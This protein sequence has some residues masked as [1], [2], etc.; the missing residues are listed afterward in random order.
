MS[1][2]HQPLLPGEPIPAGLSQALRDL[3]NIHAAYQ[4]ER[5]SQV[6]DVAW[7]DLD[8]DTHELAAD[9]GIEKPESH[10]ERLAIH[11]A[12]EDW[13]RSY[14]AGVDYAARW[15]QGCQTPTEPDTYDITLSGGGPGSCLVG[16]F[17]LG[18]AIDPGTAHYIG[19]DTQGTYQLKPWDEHQESTAWFAQLVAA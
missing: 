13:A 4:L 11:D 1:Y 10:L 16:D 2:S 5:Y 14:H 6:S 19:T 3:H 17:T 9:I 18:G 12:I 7:S 8:S 15:S